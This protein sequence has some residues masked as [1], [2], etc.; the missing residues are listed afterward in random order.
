M[1][2]KV[3][4]K[5]I[6]KK[7]VHVAIVFFLSSFLNPMLNAQV[8]N[9][10]Q[11]KNEYK[12]DLSGEWLFQVDSLD[13]GIPQQWFNKDLKDKISLPGSMTTNGKGNDID[14][15]TPWTGGIVDSSW[16]RQPEYAQY[17]V[18]GNIKVPFWLQP[19]KYY[20]GAAW[21]QKTV[22]IPSSW[23]QRHVEFFIERSHWETTVWID[24]KLAGMKNSLG[25]SHVFDLT[26]ALTPG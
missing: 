2:K 14:V 13:E 22:N 15:N 18:K 6:M 17:R 4:S 8:K 5:Y 19:I 20:K 21:Y 11:T 7:S 25:T 10:E 12:I 3:F 24:N 1:I 16:F 9:D 23:K 26:N